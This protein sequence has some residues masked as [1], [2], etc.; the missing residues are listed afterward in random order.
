MIKAVTIDLWGTLVVDSPSA[1]ERYRRERLAGLE[2]TLLRFGFRVPAADLARAYGESGRHLARIWRRW[3]DV[4]I[5]RHVT[6]LLQAVDPSLPGRVGPEALSALTTA[7]SSPALLAPPSLDEGA[8]RTLGVLA[9]S[10][11]AIGLV[12][13]TL[14]TPGAVLRTILKRQGVL[15]RLAV[16]VF[17]D[18]CGLRKPDPA[19]FDIAL[20]GLGVDRKEAVHVGD[21]PILDI[22]GARA[23]GLRVI[24]LDAGRG[25]ASRY[26]P[27]AV[28][29]RLQELPAVLADLE[30]AERRPAANRA[31]ARMR[32][33]FLTRPAAAR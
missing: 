32:P 13:N 15:D 33:R 7:Y 8:A 4:P 20:E 1:D 10:G 11:I 22:E 29:E 3:R 18:E 30:R 21:D 31:I 16:T 5:D 12:S 9:E 24:Q 6:L 26:A 23:A 27:D 2:N 14:R 25:W 19:I 28:I 17:S